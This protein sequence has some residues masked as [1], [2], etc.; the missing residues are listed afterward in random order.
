M[1]AERE[2]VLI[3]E[4]DPALSSLVSGLLDEGGY[5]PVTIAD[6]ALIPAAV[7][8]WRPGIVI[9]DGEVPATGKGRSWDDAVAIR[10][11]NPEI[12]VIMFTAD[13]DALSEAD[14]G[15]SARSRAAGFAGGVSKPFLIE[16]LLG[17][18]DAAMGESRSRATHTAD[19]DDVVRTEAVSVYPDLTGEFAA[20]RG[21]ADFVS[22]AVHEL[23]A[24]LTVIRGQMQLAR[25]RIG[26]DPVS[27]RI[28]MDLAMAQ[29]DRMT[30]MIDEVL[31]HSRLTSNALALDVI[32][33]DLATAAAEAV[34]R[35]QHAEP[36]RITLSRDETRTA[37][38]RGD[39][40]RIA[41]ILDNVLDNALKYSAPASPVSVDV[42]IANDEAQVRVTDH[43]VGVP[44]DGLA[45]L[46]TPYYRTSRTRDIAGT[47]LGLHIS[48]E[49]ARRHGGRLWLE[50]SSTAGSVFALAL[51]R[52]DS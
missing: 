3:V 37:S 23:R 48:R 47:G 26:L 44:D 45:T 46:F 9:L 25:R 15:T 34:E 40:S 5:R 7:K 31:V 50:S 32:A 21:R 43:G 39:P 36:A 1:G 12:P 4:D 13:A 24:P 38:V 22:S 51:P 18:V 35:H 27:E 29:V 41:Q 8:R 30:R 16:E 17:T 19:G 6:H 14:A 42:T 52:A 2:T 28:A 20:D 10:R 11:A 33:F 49:L